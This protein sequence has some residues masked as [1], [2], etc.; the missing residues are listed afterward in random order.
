M[1]KII[2]SS[3]FIFAGL[4]F[5]CQEVV[6]IDLEE[7]QKR[8]VVE[9]RIEKQKS[10]S[11][12]YQK[13]K[14]TTTNNYFSNE[15]SPGV[16]G[17][18]VTITDEQGKAIFFTE[19]ANQKGLYETYDLVPETGQT[20]ILSI[21]FSG[22][23]YQAVETLLPVANIDSI[24]Q[25]FVDENTFNEA[26]IRVKIDYVDPADQ[27]NYYYWEQF[28]DGIS[29]ITPNPGTK[30]T[31]VS[32]DE[33]YNGQPFLG[34]T[35]NDELIYSQG[36][37]A[38]IRQIALSEFAYKYYF[39]LFDQEGSRGGLTAPPAPIR[40]NIENLTNPDRYALGYFYASEIDEEELIV[41]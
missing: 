9:G 31:I 29:E 25:A 32:S 41:N 11:S 10:G 26:G 21:T 30:F 24:Y 28:I 4:L 39:A 27:I 6:S 36:Q 14:L 3:F 1:K 13:L 7:G 17:A 38:L 8:L 18:G 37:K 2:L 12:G 5:S 33:L 20:Y 16:S 40:G 15:S 35:P 22:E 19:N 34:K 23:K